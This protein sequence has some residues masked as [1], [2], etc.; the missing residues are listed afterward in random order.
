MRK[1]QNGRGVS[2]SALV[3]HAGPHAPGQEQRK[4]ERQERGDKRENRFPAPRNAGGENIGR[5]ICPGQLAIGQ[6]GEGG[7]RDAHL[8]HFEIAGKRRIEQRG[9][10]DGLHIHQHQQQKNAAAQKRPDFDG[11]A[12]ETRESRPRRR[13]TRCHPVTLN[14]WR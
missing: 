5:H 10:D 8:R 1:L 9:G 14:I 7:D 2:I 11:K 12:G 13:E 4:A 6:E 3:E